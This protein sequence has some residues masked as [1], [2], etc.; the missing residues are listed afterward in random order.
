MQPSVAR[1]ACASSR[2]SPVCTSHPSRIHCGAGRWSETRTSY[3]GSASS[4]RTT[5]E[6]IV[7][8]PPVTSTRLMSA[9]GWGRGIVHV[10][11]DRTWRVRAGLPDPPPRRVRPPNASACGRAEALVRVPRPPTVRTHCIQVGTGRSRGHL[12][13]RGGCSP[14]VP[15]PAVSGGSLPHPDAS[16]S[17]SSRSADSPLDATAI[18]TLCFG[19]LHRVGACQ[20]RP[21]SVEGHWN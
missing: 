10:C 15:D 19:K 20:G 7:P 12:A 11:P 16:R 5:A 3:A 2:R 14:P 9:R 21:H 17:R 4:R 13:R 8:A 6:P 18:A 1:R